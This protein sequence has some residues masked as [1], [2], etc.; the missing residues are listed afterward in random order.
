MPPIADTEELFVLGLLLVGYAGVLRAYARDRS[1][2]WLL[3]GFTALLVGRVS[4]VLEDAFLSPL[5]VVPEHGVGVGLAGLC[6]FLH[7]YT[8]AT[9]PDERGADAGTSER[10]P[11]A[12]S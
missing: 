12:E 3:L 7:F 4:T 2:R 10:S 5:W 6:F 1:A 9:R 11:V 8:L